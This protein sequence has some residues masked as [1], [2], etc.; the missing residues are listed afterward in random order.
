MSGTPPFITELNG[1]QVIVH[2][3]PDGV[4][5][6]IYIAPGPAPVVPV[7]PPKVVVSSSWSG[8]LSPA[9][10]PQVPTAPSMKKAKLITASPKILAFGD[11]VANNGDTVY[12]SG[13]TYNVGTP[14]Q[15]AAY[16][17]LS[18]ANG[19]YTVISNDGYVASST[20]LLLWNATAI[21]AGYNI[22]PIYNGSIWAVTGAGNGH[23][24]VSANGISWTE[25]TN[26]NL[27]AMFLIPVSGELAAYYVAFADLTT[28]S[29][30]YTSEDGHTWTEQNTLD[31]R[32]TCACFNG[33]TAVAIS[34]TKVY[35]GTNGIE[36]SEV[37]HG[38]S[39]A[40]NWNEV[41]WNGSVFTAI[42]SNGE[43]MTSPNGSVWTARTTLDITYSYS[44]L[45]YGN[46]LL[47][48]RNN[49]TDTFHSANGTS[50]TKKTNKPDGTHSFP[51]ITYDGTQWVAV[52][53]A[54]E[55]IGLDPVIIVST[56]GLS[57]S[58]V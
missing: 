22:A 34:G 48:T 38:V 58:T 42:N 28:Y 53:F 1:G 23:G 40:G 17:D 14:L 11:W 30:G 41:T 47:V 35:Y 7:V 20:D 4:A 16:Y 36:W 51:A 2:Y 54:P 25:Y 33:T 29:I 19:V 57:W 24:I 45:A 55:W 56:D 27:R 18:Y 32:V 3:G 13:W 26:N 10:I 50:F 5:D 21:E 43:I 46:S 15:Q 6:G 39:A 37:T 31:T 52:S 44:G 12:D 9:D 8:G 49:K